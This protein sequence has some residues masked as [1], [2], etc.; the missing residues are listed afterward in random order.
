[1]TILSAVQISV[2]YKPQYLPKEELM[3]NSFTLLKKPKLIWTL[4]PVFS[5]ANKHI[6]GWL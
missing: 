4:Y 5:A 1:M 6:L 3:D 2:L